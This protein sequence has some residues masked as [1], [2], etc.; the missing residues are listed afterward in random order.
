[1][2]HKETDKIITATTG[3]KESTHVAPNAGGDNLNYK[4]VLY[5][6]TELIAKQ[7]SRHHSFQCEEHL[8]PS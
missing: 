8:A 2:L 1:M 6:K 4:T 7:T 3:K 5:I